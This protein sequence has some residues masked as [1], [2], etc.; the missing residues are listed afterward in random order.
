VPTRRGRVPACLDDDAGQIVISGWRTPEVPAGVTERTHLLDMWVI[1]VNIS[2]VMD[3][4]I[5]EERKAPECRQPLH[6]GPVF[7][8]FGALLRTSQKQPVRERTLHAVGR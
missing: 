4:V 2:P 3:P 1:F 5:H 8:Y 7:Q 6:P